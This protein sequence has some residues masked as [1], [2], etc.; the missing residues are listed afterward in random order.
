MLSGFDLT[1]VGPPLGAGISLRAEE[2]NDTVVR[3][4]YNVKYEQSINKSTV[5]NDVETQTR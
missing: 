4:C 2:M 5:S 1:G 3:K